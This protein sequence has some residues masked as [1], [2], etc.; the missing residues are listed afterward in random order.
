MYFCQEKEDQYCFD[1]LN[2][3]ISNV[4]KI[5]EENQNK[6]KGKIGNRNQVRLI[7]VIDKAMNFKT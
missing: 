7:G 3:F 2:F 5:S 1:M 4:T 6:K